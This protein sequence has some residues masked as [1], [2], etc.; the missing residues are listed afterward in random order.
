[1]ELPH[2]AESPRAI[3]AVSAP[4]FIRY[5][6]T[7]YFAQISGDLGEN[8]YGTNELMPQ[9]SEIKFGCNALTYQCVKTS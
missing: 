9:M 2:I 7:V 3:R 8:F 4:V 5:Y 1:M 6:I